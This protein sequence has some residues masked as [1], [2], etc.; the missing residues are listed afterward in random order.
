MLKKHVRFY[1]PFFILVILIAGITCLE[2]KPTGENDSTRLTLERIFTN[3]EFSTAGFRPAR[4][5]KDGS[6]YSTLE[7]SASYP[8]SKD[9]VIHDPE[10]GDANILI[11]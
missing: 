2:S 9:L 10:T 3:Q 1:V 5:L 4:W 6:G 8:N 7:P 11:S